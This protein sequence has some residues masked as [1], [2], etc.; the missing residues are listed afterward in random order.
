[1]V[2][3][4]S[5]TVYVAAAVVGAAAFVAAAVVGFAA[6]VAAAVVGFAAFVAAAVVPVVAV[7]AEMIIFPASC[8]VSGS[9]CPSKDSTAAVVSPVTISILV[10]PVLEVSSGV[11][12]SACSPL[13]SPATIPDSAAQKEKTHL[14]P[15][16]KNN[17]R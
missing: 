10:P 12:P 1:M 14:L 5:F 6:F 2:L 9:V 13:V 4:T 15:L 11:L 8:V 7:S 16:L 3:L 17:D